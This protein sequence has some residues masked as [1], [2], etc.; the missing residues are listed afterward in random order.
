MNKQRRTSF[1]P[2]LPKDKWQ[3]CQAAYLQQAIPTFSAKAEPSQA[4]LRL[5]QMTRPQKDNTQG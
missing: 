4:V 2:I 1:L 5:I 3:K